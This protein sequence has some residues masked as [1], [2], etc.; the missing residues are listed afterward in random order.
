M[1]ENLKEQLEIWKREGIIEETTSPWAAAMVPA[2]KPDGLIRWAIDYRPLNKVTIAD[3]YPLPA[4]EENLQ[5]LAGS[6]VFSTLDATAAYHTIPVAKKSRQY[7]AFVCCFGSFTFRRMPFGP[8]NSGATY[9]RFIDSMVDKLRSPHVIAYVDDII[10][11]TASLE[12]HLQELDRVLAAHGE[13]GIKLKAKKTTLFQTEAKYLG[14]QVS[15]EGIR[16]RRD[17]VEKILEWPPPKSGKE[18]RSLLGFLSYYWSFVPNYSRLTAE[19]N[20]Q[21][22]Q[23]KIEWTKAMQE[24]LDKLKEEFQQDRIRAYPRWDIKDPF[25]VTT[26]FSAEAIAV[27][28]SQMQEGRERFIAAGGRKCT[29]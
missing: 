3:A 28:I 21:R 8:V 20:E 12:H 19:L 22:M 7:L 11:A 15:R 10:I 18:L 14:Y 9:S 13:C 5:K 4:I 16:M 25:I 17:Y 6:E 1:R 2:A 26:D 23:K 27:I 29:R 24:G